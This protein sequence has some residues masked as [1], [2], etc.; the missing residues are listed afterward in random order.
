MARGGWAPSTSG[1]FIRSNPTLYAHFTV[2]VVR[3]L[4]SPSNGGDLVTVIHNV[5]TEISGASP[6]KFV[7]GPRAGPGSFRGSAIT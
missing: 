1:Y 4:L 2:R 6:L 5:S 3:M 7:I